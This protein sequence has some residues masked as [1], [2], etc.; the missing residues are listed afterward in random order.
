M[1]WIGFIVPFAMALVNVPFF[2]NMV[3]I[4]A[5]FLCAG[6]AIAGLIRAVM[7]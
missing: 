3:N 6:I 4:A 2:P 1:K 7:D 5:C